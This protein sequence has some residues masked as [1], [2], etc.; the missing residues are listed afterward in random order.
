MAALC[1]ID[2]EVVGGGLK[3]SWGGGG[4]NYSS[5]LFTMCV[6][7]SIGQKNS[8]LANSHGLIVRMRVDEVDCVSRLIATKR[9]TKFAPRCEMEA[10]S[11]CC[12]DGGEKAR[13]RGKGIKTGGPGWK[14]KRIS[15][16]M[17]TPHNESVLRE[18]FRA[19]LSWWIFSC[20]LFSVLLSFQNDDQNGDC[21]TRSYP[22][23]FSRWDVYKIV[24]T[25]F[26]V[27]IKPIV[28]LPSL[29]P[30]KQNPLLKFGER[31]S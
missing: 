29:K 5:Q 30:R 7:R 10:M 14:G 28:N 18:Y 24:T 6:R 8:S 17:A 31:P 22:N 9:K 11:Y 12:A 19:F 15:F 13:A 25:K 3:W 21:L 16:L 2:V 27:S 20:F 23:F 26:R 1:R 4:P